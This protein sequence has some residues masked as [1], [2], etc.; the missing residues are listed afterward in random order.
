MNMSARK[1]GAPIS[2]LEMGQIEACRALTSEARGE[3]AAHTTRVQ[4]AAGSEIIGQMDISSDVY[5]M[6]S[7]RVRVNIIATTG[8][9]ITYQILEPGQLFGEFAAIDGRPRSASVVAED[10]VVLAKMPAGRFRELLARHRVRH[11]AVAGRT[12]EVADGESV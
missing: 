10:S 2:A 9:Q 1:S 12:I 3:F 8:R 4:F 11:N 7:G 6:I 5:F